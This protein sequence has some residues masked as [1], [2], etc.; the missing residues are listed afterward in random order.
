LQELSISNLKKVGCGDRIVVKGK[1][2]PCA[3]RFAVN[4]GQNP[5]NYVIHFNPRFDQDGGVIVC[6]SKI[7]SKWCPEMLISQFPFRQGEEA[8]I[9][10]LFEGKVVKVFVPDEIKFSSELKLDYVDY[11]SIDGDFEV[12]SIRIE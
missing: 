3:R 5:S 12:H 10:F 8:E 6:N 4:L 11:I 7:A 1:V 2:A 9:T